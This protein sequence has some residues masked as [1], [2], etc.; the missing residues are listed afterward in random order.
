MQYAVVF[1][2]GLVMGSFLN[3]CVYRI[4]LAK[5][6]ARPRSFCPKCEHTI[7]WFDNIPVVSFLLLRAKCR[8]CRCKI[9]ARYFFIEL[10]T[11][12]AAILLFHYFSFTPAFFVYC[13]LTCVLIVVTFIDLERQEIPD[14]FSLPGIFV[15]IALVTVF[16][17]GG[18]GTYLSSFVNSISG[19]LAGGASMFLLGFFGELIFKKEALGGGDVKLMAMIGA[20]IGWKLVI[21]TFFLAPV[22]GSGVGIFMKFKMGRDIIPYGPYLAIAAIVS[23][24]YGDKILDRLFLF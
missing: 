8:Y 5:S 2:F 17:F 23:L 6:I 1:I 4:P 21:L 11:A 3:V 19:V 9:S 13:L 10:I 22:L 20:F 18:C 12:L 15:G 7:A 24:L 14:V 16:K